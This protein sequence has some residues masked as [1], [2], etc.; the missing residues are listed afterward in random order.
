MKIV[1]A[2]EVKFWLALERL[3]KTIL[4]RSFQHVTPAQRH[5]RAAHSDALHKAPIVQYRAWISTADRN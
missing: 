4:A 2:A 3:A 1:K 5:R